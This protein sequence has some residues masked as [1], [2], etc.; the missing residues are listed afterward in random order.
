M[1]GKVNAIDAIEAAD[2][3]GAEDTEGVTDVA[4]VDG[5]AGC[6][7]RRT[8]SGE[9]VETGTFDKAAGTACSEDTDGRAG[10]KAEELPVSRNSDLSWVRAT[11]MGRAA[12]PP[13]GV[14]SVVSA[15]LPVDVFTSGAC[16]EADVPDDG[17]GGAA[18][19]AVGKIFFKRRVGD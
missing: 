18:S 6:G 9:G 15:G 1:A 11:G 13:A 7:S 17:G 2:M 4:V 14:V 19:P 3:A 10:S 12:G 5:V 16:F 8:G